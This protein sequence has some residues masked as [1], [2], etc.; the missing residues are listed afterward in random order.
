MQTTSASNMTG[1]LSEP[2]REERAERNI[3]NNERKEARH[4]QHVEGTAFGARG[5]DDAGAPKNTI[6][7]QNN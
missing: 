5:D 3:V 1:T 6:P 4:A 2:H 7:G